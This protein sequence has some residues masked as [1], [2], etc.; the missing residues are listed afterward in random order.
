M[1]HSCGI[2][3]RTLSAFAFAAFCQS[4]AMVSRGC[5]RC[6][7]LFA[8]SFRQSEGLKWILDEDSGPFSMRRGRSVCMSEKSQ[9]LRYFLSIKCRCL[10][11][12]AEPYRCVVD[13]PF[14][15]K[16]GF[17]AT[18][19]RPRS[20]KV[21]LVLMATDELHVGRNRSPTHAFSRNPF[22]SQPCYAPQDCKCRVNIFLLQTVIRQNKQTG[23]L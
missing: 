7:W 5:C 12:A 18:T 15:E 11:Y 21:G 1:R 22:P 2:R 6:C 10:I 13:L 3:D 16:R 4:S 9:D 17:K 23:M 20:L 19:Y 14:R 8:W